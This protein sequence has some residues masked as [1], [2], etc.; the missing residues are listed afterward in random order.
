MPPPAAA[1]ESLMPQP[2]EPT[3]A[4]P[5]AGSNDSHPPGPGRTPWAPGA[6]ALPEPLVAESP[7][8]AWIAGRIVNT[9]MALAR[10]RVVVWRGLLD[11]EEAQHLSAFFEAGGA[12]MPKSCFDGP[13]AGT[14]GC[15][16]TEAALSGEPPDGCAA[17]EQTLDTGPLIE[18]AHAVMRGLAQRLRGLMGWP[19]SGL[20]ALRFEPIGGRDD[21]ADD[22]FWSGAEAGRPPALGHLFVFLD[23]PL[24]G[25]ELILPYGGLTLAPARGTAVFLR[26]DALKWPARR[27]LVRPCGT[28]RIWIAAMH[29]HAAPPP[30]RQGKGDEPLR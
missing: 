18:E 26:R 4:S 29:L 15:T 1:D 12:P 27:A 13:D 5:A 6:D 8:R 21:C 11:D 25:G 22:H 2:I 28:G 10:P 3:F 23:S 16:G 20:S 9:V 7:R 17:A 30:C 14:P 24:H 19:A